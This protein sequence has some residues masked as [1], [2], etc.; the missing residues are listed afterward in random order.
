VPRDRDQAFARFTG[1]LPSVSE[2]YTKQLT[3]FTDHYPAMDKVTFSGRY[4]DRRFLVGLERPD[5][6]STAAQLTAVFNDA[7]LEA[8]VRRLPPPMYALEGPRILA[9]LKARRN[10]LGE[11]AMD[12]YRLL[13][14]DVDL[15]GT[16]GDDQIELTGRAD[17]A[18]EVSIR[19][20]GAA[21]PNLH[22]VFLPDETDEIRVYGLGG[23]DRVV[24]NGPRSS[25]AVRV[26]EPTAKPPEDPHVRFD[27]PRDWGSDLLFFPQL[28]FDTTR[29][30]VI[31]GTAH[32]TR[33]AFGRDP[34]AQYLD[35]G[36]AYSTG[37]NQPRITSMLSLLTGSPF[38]VR[39]FASYSG[40]DQVNYF[41]LGNN[42]P[43]DTNLENRNFYRIQQKTLLLHPTVEIGMGPFRPR[44]G[45]LVTSVSNVSGSSAATLGGTGFGA[46]T[47]G[48]VE[49]GFRYDSRSGALAA[50]RGVSAS[51]TARYYPQIL[52]NVSAFE[53]VR[54]EIS[55]I[56][57]AHVLTDVVVAAR[58][59]GEKNWGS[60]PFYEAA[61]IGGVPATLDDGMLASGSL[62]RGLPLNRYAGDASLVGNFE[63]RL[64]LGRY[65]Q[66]LPTRY[67][68]I[69]IVDA[70]RVFFRP[71][72]SD[73]WHVATGG[74]V[75]L[76]V[77]AAAPGYSLAT[78]LNL[79]VVTSDQGTTFY[80]ASGFGF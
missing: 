45:L 5:W 56:T 69:G 47:I 71:A 22:R 40:M 46:A 28:S 15:R 65:N 27:T 72:P 4:L 26:V 73:T 16:E 6:Q 33:Y 79:L 52:D 9:M 12:Y 20:G 3:S 36:A 21:E 68:L 67:G 11:M 25:I 48:A 23:N 51:F 41:G 75:W 63:L 7:T 30:L 49:A 42:T 29:G 13:A 64:A 66:I 74:G 8:A 61:F 43:R 53:K 78:T 2:Y 34:Y 58:I 31:G 35:L 24:R 76:A 39:L 59:A 17:G 1:F 54:G 10:R 14:Q 50:T 57:G 37:T 77:L 38:G 32:Y 55:G 18:L 80:V 44:L 70:G 62:L 60:Y 19:P